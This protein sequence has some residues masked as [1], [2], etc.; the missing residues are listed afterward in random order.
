VVDVGAGFWV[1]AGGG[2]GAGALGGFVVVVG[3]AGPIGFAAVAGPLG[4]EPAFAAPEGLSGGVSGLLG[5]TLGPPAGGSALTGGGLGAGAAAVSG[6]LEAGSFELPL[7]ETITT[8]PTITS[9]V[10]KPPPMRSSSRPLPRG[11][12]TTGCVMGELVCAPACE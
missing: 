9:A 7:P 8:A 6:V 5:V 12:A 2:E 3:V 11:G 1:A 4:G 10:A